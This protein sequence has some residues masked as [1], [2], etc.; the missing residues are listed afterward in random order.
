MKLSTLTYVAA[1]AFLVALAV[2]VRFTAQN[3]DQDDHRPMYR[4]FN[5][6]MPL[7]GSASAAASIN[8]LGWIAGDSNLTGDATQHAVVWIFG[9]P[10]NLGTL[11]GPNSAVL[12]PG[13]NDLGQIVGV[14]DTAHTD[15]LGEKWSCAAFFPASHLGHTC[16]GFLWQWGMMSPLPTL[17]GNNGFAT[18]INNHGQAVGWAETAFHDPT[19]KPPQVLQFEAVL[20]GPSPGQ[21]QVLQPY[22]GN[23]DSAAT[24]INDK[25]QVVGISGICQNA[26]GRLSA[27]RAVLWQNGTVTDMGNLG[28]AGWNTPMAI[29]NKGQVVG[30][31]DLPGDDNGNNLNFHA[32]LWTSSTGIQDLKTLPGD[33][34]SEALGVNEQGQVVGVSFDVDGNERAFLWENGRMTDL[35][36]L[37]SSDSPYTLEAG[38]DINDFGVIAG[39]ACVKPCTAQSPSFAFA[40]VPT[41]ERDSSAG[42][43]EAKIPSDSPQHVMPESVR[44]QIER[45]LVFGDRG[46]AR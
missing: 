21:K 42:T 40:A 2:P 3:I 26:V 9:F 45:R 18:A 14:S 33:V 35:N 29:N 5:L 27:E 10:L 17:G 1:T 41:G 4:V 13:Q 36:T 43:A 32:F 31:S 23:P 6:G 15:P 34:L 28:G 25:G 39:F 24:G 16:V 7:G 46:D 44:R 8:N 20:W 30:F 11:G 19:C 37:V 12:W 22:P 38:Q